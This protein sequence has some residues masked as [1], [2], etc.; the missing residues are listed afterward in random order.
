M[1]YLYKFCSYESEFHYSSEVEH[2][3]A[4]F[5]KIIEDIEEK[6]CQHIE[7]I[8]S[9]YTLEI[10]EI[11]R[12]ELVEKEEG[13]YYESGINLRNILENEYGMKPLKFHHTISL[14]YGS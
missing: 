9:I 10:D 5:E 13:R 6:Y 2:D 11:S 12:E 1:L 3:P 7:N 4:I 14:G 8:N